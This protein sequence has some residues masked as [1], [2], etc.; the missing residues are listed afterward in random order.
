M[1][2]GGADNEAARSNVDG[3]PY[4]PLDDDGKLIGG[5]QECPGKGTYY[6]CDDP[7]CNLARTC[8]GLHSCACPDTGYPKP[9][10]VTP[11]SGEHGCENPQ[12]GCQGSYCCGDDRCTLGRTCAG[13]HSC[14]CPLFGGVATTT[15]AAPTICDAI[16]IKCIEVDVTVAGTTDECAAAAAPFVAVLPECAT[17]DPPLLDAASVCPACKQASLER[18]ESECPDKVAAWKAENE[19]SGDSE[20]SAASEASAASAMIVAAVAVAAAAL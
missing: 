5:A 15:T 3:Y 1:G 4:I 7:V 16:P 20:E 2:T 17:C 9:I 13:L 18:Y 11:V 19:G 14:A 10:P 12:H 8:G 6:S